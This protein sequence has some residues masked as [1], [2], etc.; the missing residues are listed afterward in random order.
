MRMRTASGLAAA[1][2]AIVAAV[3]VLEEPHAA[4]Q[5]DTFSDAVLVIGD[6]RPAAWWDCPEV[7]SAATDRV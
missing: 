7:P 4:V 5:Q 3:V 6:E 1:S 2:L